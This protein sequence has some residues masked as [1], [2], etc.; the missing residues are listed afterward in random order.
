[1]NFRAMRRNRQQ[2]THEEC[3]KILD[4]STS[5]VLSLIGDGGY[6]YGVPMSYVYHNGKIFFHSAT[7]GHKID[8]IGTEEKCSFT[9]IAQD[10]VHNEEYTT[11]FRSVIVFGRIHIIE[12]EAEKLAALRSLGERYNPNDN[13]GLQ[14]E[15]DKGFSHLHILRLDIEHISGKESIELIKAKKQ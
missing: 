2:L 8:A 4:K 15:I 1:M 13:A 6:P 11:Y 5:G 9:I 3:Q 14:R 7:T 10:D 12:D